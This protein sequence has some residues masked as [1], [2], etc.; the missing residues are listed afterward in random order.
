MYVLLRFSQY[1]WPV[2]TNKVKHRNLHPAQQQHPE[3]VSD[4]AMSQHQVN[5]LTSAGFAHTPA[6]VFF[7]VACLANTPCARG[8]DCKATTTSEGR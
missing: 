4:P 8:T 5:A 2:V 3:T 6:T 1:S 7:D